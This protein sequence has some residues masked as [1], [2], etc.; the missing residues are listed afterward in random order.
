MQ[1]GLLNSRLARDE[2]KP[3]ASNGGN[4]W[5]SKVV[6]AIMAVIIAG[7]AGGLIAWGSQGAAIEQHEKRLTAS[8]VIQLQDGRRLQSLCDQMADIKAAQSAMRQEIRQDLDGLR[9]L[10]IEKRG[11]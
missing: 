3:M 7:T 10:L 5:A 6:W 4:G 2:V 8:E 1:Y 9:R 11:R